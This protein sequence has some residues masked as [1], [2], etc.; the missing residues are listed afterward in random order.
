MSKQPLSTLIY[1][2]SKIQQINYAGQIDD[3]GT[4]G[5]SV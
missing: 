5:T 4:S 2:N 1:N 3:V